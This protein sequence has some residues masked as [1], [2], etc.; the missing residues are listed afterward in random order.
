MNLTMSQIQ[1]VSRNARN[2]FRIGWY[3][4]HTNEKI[5]RDINDQCTQY[6]FNL[7]RVTRANT[8]VEENK[9]V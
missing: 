2:L 8:L 9:N 3:S 5:I 6:V 1:K 7:Y 4:N